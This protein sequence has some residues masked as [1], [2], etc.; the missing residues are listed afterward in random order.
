MVVLMSIVF[1]ATAAVVLAPPMGEVLAGMLIPRTGTDPRT[2]LVALGL[3]GT[4]VVPYNLF[5]HAAAV[6]ERWQGPGDLPAAR[7]D[8]TIA[9]IGGGIISMAVVVTAAGALGGG[10]HQRV[11]DGRP[12]RAAPRPLGTHPSSP[13]AS[14]P[15][16]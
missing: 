12:A 6:R 2:L 3:V 11:R 15:P 5:L 9:I 1:L 4:T 13:R 14:S 16:A 8:L 10:R 7:L